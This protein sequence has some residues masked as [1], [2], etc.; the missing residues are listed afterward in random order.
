MKRELVNEVI[1]VFSDRRRVFYYFKDRYCLDLIE[2]EMLRRGVDRITI[3]ELKSGKMARYLNKPSV[4]QILGL[5]GTGVIHR[6]VIPLLGPVDRIPFTLGFSCWG[7]GERGWDQ[8]SRN[9]SNLV[10]QLNFD[11]GHDQSYQ[12]LVRPTDRY[13][14]FESWCHPVSRTTRKTLAWVRM[15]IDFETDE[16]LIEE[17]QNDWLRDAR[18]T[19]QRIERRIART[20]TLKPRDINSDID[21]SLENL[22]EYVGVTLKPF[23]AIWAEAAMLAAIRFVKDELG[24]S[25]IYYHSFE[26]GKK[27]KGGCGNPPRS[28]YSKLP[29]EF[30]FDSTS[31]APALL[32]NHRFARRCLKAIKGPSWYYMKV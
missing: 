16:V 4:S 21:G 15:D 10:L 20:P 12:C 19:L 7:N 3:S 32:A 22:R 27:L 8:T 30:G 17:V 13:G 28:I 18:S 25:N 9:Q 23:E 31:E 26:T 1:E 14:P 2:L 29:K 5:L 24:I 6:E 11:G